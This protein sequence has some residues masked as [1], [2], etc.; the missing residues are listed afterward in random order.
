MGTKLFFS[1]GAED[2]VSPQGRR[3]LARE[4]E[5]EDQEHPSVG[6]LAYSQ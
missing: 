6:C 5:V 3:I 2:P 1:K 4:R